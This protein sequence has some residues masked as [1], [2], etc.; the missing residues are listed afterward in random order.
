MTPVNCSFKILPRKESGNVA[1]QIKANNIMASEN[2]CN[3][4]VKKNTV[5]SKC[6]RLFDYVRGI[7]QNGSSHSWY[8][9]QR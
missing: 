8:S 4:Q 2:V 1:D 6:S 9:K 3:V 7:T 5:V